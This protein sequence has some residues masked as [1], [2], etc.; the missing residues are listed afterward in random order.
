M[1]EKIDIAL[2]DLARLIVR[3]MSNDCPGDKLLMS[4]IMNGHR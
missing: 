4:R 3:V 2:M 1:V